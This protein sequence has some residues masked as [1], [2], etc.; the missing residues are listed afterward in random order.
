MINVECV[1]LNGPLA[2][3]S[4]TLTRQADP[5]AVGDVLELENHRYTI[6]EV[7]IVSARHFRCVVDYTPP[8]PARPTAFDPQGPGRENGVTTEEGVDAQV[9]PQPTSSVDPQHVTPSL[10]VL[11]GE[12]S[13]R[14]GWTSVELGSVERLLDYSP[15]GDPL[16]IL[17]PAGD[18]DAAQARAISSMH[19]AGRAVLVVSHATP[20]VDLVDWLPKDAWVV[21]D[22]GASNRDRMISA[23]VRAA[24]QRGWG[25]VAVVNAEELSGATPSGGALLVPATASEI[26][27]DTVRTVASLSGAGRP[28]LVVVDEPL[29]DELLA[30]APQ[31]S[32]LIVSGAAPATPASAV[33]E[34]VTTAQELVEPPE[35]QRSR[36]LDQAPA[37]IRERALDP[38]VEARIQSA[39]R[40]STAELLWL[41]ALDPDPDVRKA[42]HGNRHTPADALRPQ[43]DGN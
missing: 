21:G 33:N 10:L 4:R 22:A 15:C 28:V 6:V 18:L 2:G 30:W 41:L 36:R 43:A 39:T 37:W 23:G 12:E 42:A 32:F 20:P 11:A 34:R 40:S 8:E 17:S 27:L 38:E 26:S 13:Q 24:A 16:V 9:H 25:D 35:A 14:R 29:S 7:G 19:G 3:Q 31:D 5:L 1:A